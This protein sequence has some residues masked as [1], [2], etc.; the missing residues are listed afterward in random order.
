MQ[1]LQSL[2]ALSLPL[3]RKIKGPKVEPLFIEYTIP[4]LAVN[5]HVLPKPHHVAYGSF[6]LIV[7]YV[8]ELDL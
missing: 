2:F 1:L 7:G 5:G 3:I 6:Q 8:Q 4:L